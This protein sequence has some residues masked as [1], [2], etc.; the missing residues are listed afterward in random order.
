MNVSWHV[1]HE[2]AQNLVILPQTVSDKNETMIE[3][4]D[5]ELDTTISKVA[6]KAEYV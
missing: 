6:P 1:A 2:D 5:A 4:V 3:K